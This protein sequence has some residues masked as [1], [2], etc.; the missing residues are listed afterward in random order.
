MDYQALP[1]DDLPHVFEDKLDYSKLQNNKLSWGAI[2][3][4]SVCTVLNI[5]L[6]IKSTSSNSYTFPSATSFLTTR[7]M[8]RKDIDSLRRPSQ[9]I[10][11][12]KIHRNKTESAMTKSF[13]NFPILMT[14][15]DASKPYEV[16]KPRKGEQSKIGTVYPELSD[17]IATPSVSLFTILIDD[18][19]SL[20]IFSR[21]LRSFNFEQS[22]MEW[23]Y[24]N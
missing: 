18:F 4:C 13:I 1:A 10:G 19:L 15:I 20:I 12:D 23:N 21:F 22:I 14:Q 17:M 2:L 3:V 9:F 6:T 7:G 16:T 5:F 8:T 24:V 11:L